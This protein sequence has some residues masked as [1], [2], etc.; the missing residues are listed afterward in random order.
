MQI[1]HFPIYY[2][3]DNYEILK[4]YENLQENIENLEN[5]PDELTFI[6]RGEEPKLMNPLILEDFYVKN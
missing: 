6:V 2:C 5:Q 3:F 1:I 4:I